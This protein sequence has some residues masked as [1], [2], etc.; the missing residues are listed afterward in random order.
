MMVGVTSDEVQPGRPVYQLFNKHKRR[1]PRV[2]F[3]L[4]QQSVLR[5]AGRKPMA[6]NDDIAAELALS[7]N[8]VRSIWAGVYHAIYMAQTDGRLPYGTPFSYEQSGADK[9]GAVLTFVANNP[10]EVRP[11]HRKYFNR[12]GTRSHARVVL[13]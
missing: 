8:R 10:V 4:R 6:T 3:T 9:R 2:F 5:S 11:V 13:G 1:D 7:D 12:Q